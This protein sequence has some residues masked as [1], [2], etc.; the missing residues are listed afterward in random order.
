MNRPENYLSIIW[1]IEKV[2]PYI[3]QRHQLHVVGVNPNDCFKKYVS[4]QIILTGK[5]DYVDKYFEK[6]VCPGAP[7]LIGAGIKLKFLNVGIWGC[8]TNHIRIERINAISGRHY[9]HCEITEECINAL[10]DKRNEIVFCRHAAIKFMKSTEYEYNE[11]VL[12]VKNKIYELLHI[13]IEFRGE[14][15]SYEYYFAFWRIRKKTLAA[16]E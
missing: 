9:I 12:L 5:I 11:F 15:L 14:N 6:M 2:M 4:D 13:N 3:D 1:F 10:N 16:V 8:I 7:L